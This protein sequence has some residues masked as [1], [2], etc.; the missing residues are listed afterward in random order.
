MQPLIIFDYLLFIFK[1]CVLH[2]L[3][4]FIMNMLMKKFG[5]HRE[6]GTDTPLVEEWKKILMKIFDSN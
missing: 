2:K 6:I 5:L 4:F 1:I 3:F